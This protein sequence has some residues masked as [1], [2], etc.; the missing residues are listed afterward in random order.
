[1]KTPGWYS[2]KN[3]NNY[4]H[5]KRHSSV[6]TRWASMLGRCQ[7][8]NKQSY[9]NYGGR[10]IKVC[11]RWMKFENFY[12][13]MGDPPPGLTLERLDVN[14]DYCPSNC[15]WAT[16]KVQCNN[17]R[18]VK[19]F[20]FNGKTLTLSEWAVETG[21]PFTALSA[22]RYAGWSIERMLTESIRTW[23]SRT[24]RNAP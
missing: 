22:R 19:K 10:G 5:G 2:G 12:A 17:Q 13:D 7:N 4:K 18:H 16:Q 6:Y 21:F 20:T 24:N 9:R 8:P 1:M 23:P 15:T 11:E 14:G 3:N